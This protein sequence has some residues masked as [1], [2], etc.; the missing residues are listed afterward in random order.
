MYCIRTKESFDLKACPSQ[1]FFIKLVDLAEAF[2]LPCLMDQSLN[3]LCC[4]NDWIIPKYGEIFLSII[5]KL[6]VTGSL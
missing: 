5:S 4:L 6:S 3:K 1:K 2:L